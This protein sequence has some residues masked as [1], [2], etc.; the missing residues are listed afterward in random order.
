MPI[1]LCGPTDS[2]L[3]ESG[4]VSLVCHPS[5]MSPRLLLLRTLQSSSPGKKHRAL[6]GLTRQWT[7]PMTQRKANRHA[8]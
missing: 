2:P 8:T 4:P 6:S 7:Q 5:N 3:P 1:P